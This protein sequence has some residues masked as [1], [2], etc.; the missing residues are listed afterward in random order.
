MDVGSAPCVVQG[1]LASIEVLEIGVE[2][3]VHRDFRAV[4]TDLSE[5]VGTVGCTHKEIE[6][7]LVLLA[8]VMR[9]V[10]PLDALEVS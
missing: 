4:S 3:V 1:V 5:V 2:L 9:R 8:G 6:V 7:V 10:F